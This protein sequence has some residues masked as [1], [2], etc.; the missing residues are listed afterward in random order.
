MSKFA[1]LFLAVFVGGILAAVLYDSSGAFILYQLVYFLDPAERWWGKA[2]PGISYAFISSI[3]MIAVLARDYKNL[4][5][6]SPW[7]SHPMF[8]WM[9]ALVICYYVAFL[10]ALN[11]PFHTQFTYNYMKLVV[12]VFVA[13]KLL[14]NKK[15]LD[16]AIWAYLIGATYIGY[17]ATI[18][19]RNSGVRVEGIALPSAGTD[20]N[21]VAAA[22]VPAGVL[23]LY[24]AWMGNKKVKLLC[25]VCG[26]LVANG[27][28]LF[29]S[30][31][32]FLGTVASAGFFLLNMMFSRHRQ[33]GQRG[34]AILIVILSIAGAFRMADN[35]FWKRMSTLETPENK[36]SGSSRVE[37]WLAALRMMEVHPEGLGVRGFN[38]LAPE[39]LTNRQRGGILFRSVHSMW[40]QGL[41]EVGWHGFFFFLALLFTLYRLSR[42]AK[43]T[44]IKEADYAAYFKILALECA[45]FGYLV[46]GTFINEFRA[47][48]MY[49]MMLLLG[50]ATKVYYLQPI[51]EREAAEKAER[52]ARLQAQ[53]RAV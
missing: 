30:R 50:V 14:R 35:T 27:L 8:I 23:L 51:A 33:R 16:A 52:K 34:M 37:F 5:T 53:R 49:W 17:L 21:P 20:V 11:M 45:L 41:T 6:L 15:T 28:V 38:M 29:N 7:R 44:M 40:F 10:W 46:A 9:F 48:V 19:G 47:E 39:Y 26:A 1:L 43:L 36:D 32:A 24:F 22:I 25:F 3:L 12:V 13:Y 18:T 4:S 42:R 2:L 31:G